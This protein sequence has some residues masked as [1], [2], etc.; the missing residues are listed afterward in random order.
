MQHTP[1][2]SK[3]TA[4]NIETFLPEVE[5]L[6]DEELTKRLKEYVKDW[7]PITSST[8]STYERKLAKLIADDMERVA[9][10]NSEAALPPKQQVKKRSHVL[11]SQKTKRQRREAPCVVSSSHAVVS[12]C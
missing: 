11:T 6:S 4:L 2:K 5:I 1:A 7:G 9:M 12:S 8:R 3:K 10:L